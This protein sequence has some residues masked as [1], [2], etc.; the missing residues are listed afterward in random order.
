MSDFFG[1]SSPGICITKLHASVKGFQPRGGAS[2]QEVKDTLLIF[3]GADREQSH[4]N[5]CLVYRTK[6]NSSIFEAGIAH[7]DI[8]MERSGHQTAAYGK[9]QFLFGGIN[10]A[11]ESVF[12]DLYILNTETFEWNYVG[13]SGKEIPSRNSHSMAVIH[14]GTTN[15]LVVF[16]GASPESGPMGDTFYAELPDESGIDIKSVYVTWKEL[17]S[18]GQEHPVAREMHS[19]CSYRDRMIISGGRSGEGDI[20]SDVWEL[21]PSD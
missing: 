5:D 16:G 11:E 2:L 21:S 14:G 12:N 17:E 8:P 6:K 13:E 1:K 20:L 4:Y 7:G 10:F 9:Y 3:G 19:T 18:S 15:Y